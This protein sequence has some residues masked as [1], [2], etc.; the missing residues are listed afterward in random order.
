[1][2]PIKGDRD[3][4]TQVITNL[5]NN[6]IKYSPE[7][8]TILVGS[9]R[10]SNAVHLFVQDH[11]IGIPPEKL[12]QIFERYARVESGATRYIGG[13]GLGLPIVRQIVE[14]HHGTVWAESIMGEGST[15]H[16]VLPSQHSLK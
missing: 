7:G 6:A 11:G 8:G 15:F 14:M 5:V 16:V 1:M 2:P 13:T 12:E 4:L 3:K 9:R 10:E